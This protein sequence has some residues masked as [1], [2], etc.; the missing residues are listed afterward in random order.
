MSAGQIYKLQGSI[1]STGPTPIPA[2]SGFGT[3]PGQL[4]SAMTW[5]CRELRSCEF[6]DG[7]GSV[8]GGERMIQ[9]NGRRKEAAEAKAKTRNRDYETKYVC[10]PSIG[11]KEDKWRPSTVQAKHKLFNLCHSHQIRIT[12]AAVHLVVC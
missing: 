9:P 12:Y 10:P 7:A 5:Q 3:I 4:V 8:E 6:A 11:P 1:K 2:K